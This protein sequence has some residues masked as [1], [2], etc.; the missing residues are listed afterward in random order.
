MHFTAAESVGRTDAAPALT[1]VLAPVTA[2]I[3][4]E[5]WR[6]RE[7]VISVESTAATTAFFFSFLF[8]E[9]TRHS[10]CCVGAAL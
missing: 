4:V 2:A 6:N 9:G 10:W 3:T 1:L 8:V 7:L 5:P